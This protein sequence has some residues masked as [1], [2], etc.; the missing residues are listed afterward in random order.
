MK[1]IGKGGE[2]SI[3]AIACRW[4]VAVSLIL[5]VFVP[6]EPFAFEQNTNR[7]GGDYHHFEPA[8]PSLALCDKMCRDGASYSFPYS[9][10]R[11]MAFTYTKPTGS[12]PNGICWLKE[13]IPSPV[14]DLRYVSGVVRRLVCV[15]GNAGQSQSQVTGLEHTGW[16]VDYDVAGTGSWLQYS[17]PINEDDMWIEGV[18]LRFTNANPKFGWIAAVHV[19]DGEAKVASFDVPQGGGPGWSEKPETFDLLHPFDKPIRVAR[20]VGVSILPQTYVSGVSN[21][22]STWRFTAFACSS[23]LKNQKIE[24]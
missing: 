12:Y 19:Y 8:S 23:L 21:V 20:G 17:I 9:P 6:G 7:P 13:K 24:R 14:S 16:G 3:Q 5:I 15:H 2:K 10:L 11:C 1:E 4:L 22:L 18:Y